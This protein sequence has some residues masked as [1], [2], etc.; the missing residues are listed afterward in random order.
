MQ[1]KNDHHVFFH[2]LPSPIYWIS[3]P[4]A[5]APPNLINPR[6]TGCPSRQRVAGA[7][8]GG[9]AGAVDGAAA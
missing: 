6:I 9:G 1:Y 4:G 8:C 2:Q 7:N 3:E 5:R